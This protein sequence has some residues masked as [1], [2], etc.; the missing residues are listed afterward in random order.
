MAVK[1]SHGNLVASFSSNDKPREVD[2]KRLDI[3]AY[4]IKP[5][6]TLSDKDGGH[7]FVWNLHTKEGL[8]VPPGAYTLSLQIGNFPEKTVTLQVLRDPR[9]PA[10]DEDLRTQYAFAQEVGAEVAS[11]QAFMQKA[12]ALIKS[13][14]A[15]LSP[16]K[17]DQLQELLGGG[18]GGRRRRRI[19]GTPDMGGPDDQD[20][21]SLSHISSALAGLQGAVESAPAAPSPEHRHAYSVLKKRAED[22]MAAIKQITG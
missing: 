9:V 5:E 1:D 18:G 2:F 8:L 11:V 21:S 22:A 6:M 10:S 7:R 15:K 4:W 13:N 19:Q 12:A 14:S 3:P 20:V 16:D 17:L